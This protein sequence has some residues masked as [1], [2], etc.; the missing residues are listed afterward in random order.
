MYCLLTSVNYILTERK[1]CLLGRKWRIAFKQERDSSA[2]KSITNL[3]SLAHLGHSGD[4]SLNTI[5]SQ[6]NYT[7]RTLSR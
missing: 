6:Q 4:T 1:H 2:S 3:L 5:I 7:L